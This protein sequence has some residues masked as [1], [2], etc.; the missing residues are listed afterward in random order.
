MQYRDVLGDWYPL[1]SER[2]DLVKL[3]KQLGNAYLSHQVYPKPENIF[4]IFKLLS[5]KDVRV[6]IVGQSP[7]HNGVASGIAFGVENDVVTDA[8]SDGVSDA[9]KNDGA[10]VGAIDGAKIPPT[11]NIIKAE[12]ENTVYPLE[13]REFDYTLMKWVNQGVFMYNTSLTVIEGMPNS[14]DNIWMDFTKGVMEILNETPGLIWCL[15]GN[16]AKKCK[17][18][19][20]PMFH[21]ILEA[22]HPS[23][24]CYKKAAGFYDCDHFNLVNEIIIGQNGREFEINW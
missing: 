20:N 18:Y 3:S 11:L 1:L 23:A 7:Y 17:N 21:H 2:V 24:E 8:I 10:S 22:A 4:R 6:V 19:I 14:H 13:P 5:P 15:W 9:V 16:D 12:V